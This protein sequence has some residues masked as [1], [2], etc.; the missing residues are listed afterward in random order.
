MAQAQF[1][2]AS[3]NYYHW[4]SRSRGK[5]NLNLNGTGGERCAVWFTEDPAATLPDAAQIA[6]NYYSFYYHLHQLPTLIDM[7]CNEGPVF[8][9]FNDDNGWPNSRISTSNEPVGEGE[10]SG[11]P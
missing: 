3:Y 11:A 4:S 9:Y 1:Q 8:V 6:P 7:L 5:V 2:V 10:L